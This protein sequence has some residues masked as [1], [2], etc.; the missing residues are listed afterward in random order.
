MIRMQNIQNKNDVPLR[1]DLPMQRSKAFRLRDQQIMIFQ[2]MRLCL[3]LSLLFTLVTAQIAF[4]LPSDSQKLLHIHSKTLIV[5][6]GKRQATYQGNVVVTQGSRYL[7]GNTLTLNQNKQGQVNRILLKG[8]PAHGHYQPKPN[9]PDTYSKAMIML[10]QPLKNLITLKGNAHITHN[11]NVFKGPLITYNTQTQ[12]LTTPHNQD[13]RNT[14][15]L[16]P[17]S[18]IEKDK[19]H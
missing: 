9:H 13:T 2:T 16:Q 14:M 6:Y 19:D 18:D 3:C 15:I 8:T 7:S 17:Y 11:G 10:Y 5:R 1:I 12:I 4:S